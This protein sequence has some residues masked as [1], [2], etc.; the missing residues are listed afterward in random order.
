MNF[1]KPTQLKILLKKT[2]KNAKKMKTAKIG[3]TVCFL[4][5]DKNLDHY[6]YEQSKDKT[7]TDK[8][9]KTANFQNV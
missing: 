2:G 9:E 8:K 5:H 4:H 6:Q 7:K 1:T 3:L